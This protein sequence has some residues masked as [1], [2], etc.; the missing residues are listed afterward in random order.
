MN[1][2]KYNINKCCRN[3]NNT[4]LCGNIQVEILLLAELLF[5][6]SMS[7]G[8]GRWRRWRVIPCAS[9]KIKD[10]FRCHTYVCAVC[11]VMLSPGES[12]DRNMDQE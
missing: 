2:K 8:G 7:G 6:F 9:R 12:G 11:A 1:R 3:S 4:I 5:P 10:V